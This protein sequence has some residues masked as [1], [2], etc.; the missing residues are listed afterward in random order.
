MSCPCAQHH[1]KRKPVLAV[2]DDPAAGVIVHCAGGCSAEEIIGELQRR[3][4]IPDP[5]QQDLELEQPTSV[6]EDTRPSVLEALALWRSSRTI[7]G[8][9]GEEF[10]TH[11]G[12]PAPPSL[13]FRSETAMG[14]AMPVIIAALQASDRKISG[15]VGLMLELSPRERYRRPRR[16]IGS[17]RIGQL[18]D[19]AVRLGPAAERIALAGSV[20]AALAAAKHSGLPVWAAVYANRIC[21]VALPAIVQEVVVFVDKTGA[22]RLAAQRV[23]ETHPQRK[24]SIVFPSDDRRW[25]PWD[26]RAEGEGDDG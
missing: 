21:Q 16:V 4:V 12:F 2:R 8:S 19:G 26:N 3:G 14:R 10:L 20:P 1:E 15:V 17:V 13:R 6:S 9:A 24:I 22:G 23:T 18:D 5:R 25:D 7:A 11:L